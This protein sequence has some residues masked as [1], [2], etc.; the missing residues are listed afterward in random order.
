VLRILA[1]WATTSATPDT[2][3]SLNSPFRI[4]GA[5]GRKQADEKEKSGVLCQNGVVNRICL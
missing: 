4:I 5:F 1:S 3:I 2:S